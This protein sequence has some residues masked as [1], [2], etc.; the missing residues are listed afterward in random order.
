MYIENQLNKIARYWR[1]SITDTL[2]MP[3]EE[4]KGITSKELIKKYWITEI[5]PKGGL[6][7][8][9]NKRLIKGNRWDWGKL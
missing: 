8:I 1:V 7:V 5:L 9:K 4:K 6:L 3:G 2:A